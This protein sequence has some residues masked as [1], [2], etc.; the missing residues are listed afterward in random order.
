MATY[1]ISGTGTNVG[2][3]V[4]T[5]WLAK[6]ALLNGKKAITQKFIQTGGD[7]ISED[8]IMHRKIMAIPLGEF[9][10][11]LTTSPCVLKFPSSPHLAAELEARVIDFE[12]IKNSIKTLE[13]NFEE[14]FLE[15]AGGLMVPL[16]KDYL[17]IDYVAENRLPL[18]IVADARLGTLNH[19]LL[20]IFAALQRGII[21]SKFIFNEYNSCDE[22]ILEDSKRYLQNHLA[23]VSPDT[24]FLVLPKL[25]F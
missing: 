10:L 15:G 18:I 23:K 4:A 22:Q 13:E 19:S 12:L 14:V 8:V 24:E 25:S 16:S 2:K 11:Q 5:G 21:I 17:T 3:S 1:F 9:D 7:G 6:L 20:T